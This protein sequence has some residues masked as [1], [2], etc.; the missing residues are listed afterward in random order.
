MALIPV[1]TGVF[2][3]WRLTTFG[4]MRSIGR[5]S[6]GVDRALAVDRLADRVDHPPDH[7]R[8][9]RDRHQAAGAVHGLSFGDARRLTHDDD[10]DAADFKVEHD[11]QHAVLELHHF[12]GAR[13]VQPAHTRDTI[14]DLGHRAYFHRAGR[15]LEAQD[16]LLELIDQVACAYRHKRILPSVNNSLKRKAQNVETWQGSGRIYVLRFAFFVLRDT[17]RLSRAGVSPQS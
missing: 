10:A 4:A 17:G 1:C 3:F 5:Y 15:H 13:V 2:T 7:L 16:L 14:S 8:A 11:P 6:L 9:D 12:R